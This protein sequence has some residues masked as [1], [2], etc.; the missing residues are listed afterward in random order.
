MKSNFQNPLVVVALIFLLKTTLLT[1]F[2]FPR[3]VR[4]GNFLKQRYEMVEIQIIKRDIKDKQ[5]IKA[6]LEVPRHKF[7]P[8]NLIEKAYHDSPLSIGYGRLYLNHM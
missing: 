6:M 8:D 1:S 2:A 4:K 5:V 3:Q 7:V